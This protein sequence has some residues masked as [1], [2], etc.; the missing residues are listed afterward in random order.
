MKLVKL[1]KL[2]AVTAA[3]AMVLSGIGVFADDDLLTTDMNEQNSGTIVSSS[4]VNSGNDL[5]YTEDVQPEEDIQNNGQDVS[6]D[7]YDILTN[8]NLDFIDDIQSE[9]YDLQIDETSA[10]LAAVTISN[11][12]FDYTVNDASSVILSKLTNTSATEITIPKTITDAGTEYK[13]IRFDAN[14]FQNN[15]TLE[16]VNLPRTIK[17]IPSWSFLGCTA[18]REVITYGDPSGDDVFTNVGERSFEECKALTK[19]V[20]PNTVKTI[21]TRAFNQCESLSSISS[22]ENVTELGQNAFA[23][24]KAL[25]SIDLPKVETLGLY[26]LAST[27]LTSITLPDTAV[28]M[29]GSVFYNCVD[30][31]SAVL[32]KK[33]KTI[34]SNSFDGCTSL[35]SVE[36]PDM[37]TNIGRM[38]FSKCAFTDITIPASVTEFESNIF[39]GCPNLT[40]INVDAGNSVFKSD[41][42]GI[43]YKIAESDTIYAFPTGKENVVLPSNVTKIG[44]GAFSGYTKGSIT[45]PKQVTSIGS[46]A[47]YGSTALSSLNFESPEAVTPELSIEYKAFSGVEGITEIALPARLKSIGTESLVCPNMNKVTFADNS[48][49]ESIGNH[50][51][52]STQIKSIEFP[53]SL[54]K[55][56]KNLF[57]KGVLD[58]Q[59]T[60]EHLETVT[61]A[62]GSKLESIGL[63]AFEKAVN[64]KSVYIPA[65]V[66]EI[67]AHAFDGCQSLTNVIFESGSNLQEISGNSFSKT[68]ITEID[69]PDSV[70]MI[71]VSA[72]SD[73]KS[74]ETVNISE[75]SKLTTLRG[76]FVGCSALKSIYLPDGLKTI[77]S[78]EFSGCSMLQS[79]EIPDSVTTI[80]QYAFSGCTSLASVKLSKKI[81]EI[82]YNAF[83]GA[84]I[85]E[86]VIPANVA[87]V[88][89]GAFKNCKNLSKVVLLSEEPIEINSG[90]FSGI[91][92]Y[93]IFYSDNEDVKTFVDG[94]SGFTLKST[95][96][97]DFPETHNASV[98]LVKVDDKSYN[99]K[100][101]PDVGKSIK[102]FADIH[103]YVEN[104]SD[105]NSAI[106]YT[107]EPADDMKLAYADDARGNTQYMIYV[108]PSNVGVANGGVVPI[109]ANGRV[110][111]TIKLDG[112]G[113]G[114]LAIVNADGTDE[115]SDSLV[116]NVNIDSLRTESDK[117]INAE[118][119]YSIIQPMQTLKVRVTFPNAVQD[120]KS[121]YQSMKLTISGGDLVD[122]IV[123]DFGTDG[124]ALNDAGSYV[125]EQELTQNVSYN[126]TVEG[127]G[128]RT[129]RYT[130]NMSED[131]ELTFWNNVLDDDNASVVETGKTTG[132][133]TKNFLAGD[134]VKDN[135][136]NLYDLSAVVSYF[137]TIDLS[138]TNHPEYAKYDLNR[139]GKID[140][141]DVAYVLVSWGE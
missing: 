34:P 103:F 123:K 110:I 50:A 2:V 36:I 26:S 115:K 111:G 35:A 16:V 97:T 78:M 135:Q 137:G 23:G 85:T 106:G 32:S 119:E 93:A 68:A 86:V 40:S 63:C 9:E 41:D 127:A 79:I 52:S 31:Q 21:Y 43:V 29:S 14:A 60:A 102:A 6:G 30:L 4:S 17:S 73:C 91:D 66:V 90:S 76:S 33:L 24:C 3:S 37:V 125:I 122:D 55:I 77:E 141:K 140:S 48:I 74:L 8:N 118:T 5:E 95:S 124:V 70:V 27:G 54:K 96:E 71:N 139:D 65:S 126:V 101:Y 45:I 99:I 132:K 18:L 64:L 129:A 100:L 39:S 136:I 87:K 57:S 121:A 1:K 94:N 69:I 15:T 51:F 113:A 10:S 67:E 13:V 98:E 105:E 59:N 28:N 130:V 58:S 88:D 109:P 120:N 104:I 114:S 38:A 22:L 131:K 53:A 80:G 61:F 49:L 46:N 133:V 75:N 117:V 82:P 62:S 7:D 89:N 19:V 84:A 83:S 81:T 128:Y 12:D 42:E 72:F 108:K 11:G 20:L 47:F 107:V 134:I 56:G 112:F 116:N 44:D 92:S 25:K 138:E